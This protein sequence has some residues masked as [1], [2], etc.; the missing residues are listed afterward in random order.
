MAR[1][2]GKSN[3]ASKLGHDPLAWLEGTPPSP[4][5]STEKKQTGIQADIKI[6]SEQ[7]TENNHQNEGNAE[8]ADSG[9]GNT[10]EVGWG[11]FEEDVVSDDIEQSST[12]GSE[13]NNGWGLFEETEPEEPDHAAYG[14]F[15]ED[16]PDDDVSGIQTEGNVVKLPLSCVLATL[17]DIKRYADSALETGDDIVI[18]AGDVEVVD[19]A[20]LQFIFALVKESK[21]GG[22]NIVWNRVSDKFR[23]AAEL[24]DLEQ[25]LCF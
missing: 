6:T 15:S 5:D 18:D 17:V 21:T 7:A 1:K 23:C 20:A 4:T 12:T 10:S 25:Q 2:S 11:L 8:L 13:D 9:S 22:I 3:S 24:C 19:A 16:D 14:L